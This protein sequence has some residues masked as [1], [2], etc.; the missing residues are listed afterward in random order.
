[1]SWSRRS[2]G[3]E[4][5]VITRTARPPS[6]LSPTPASAAPRAIVIASVSGSCGDPGSTS[7]AGISHRA[8]CAT[9]CT[10]S[11]ANGLAEITVNQSGRHCYCQGGQTRHDVNVGFGEAER[12]QVQPAA[13]ISTARDSE[14]SGH[15]RGG[16]GR[17]PADEPAAP[18]LGS[19]LTEPDRG[20]QEGG[21][22]D[23]PVVGPGNRRDQQAGD[24][25][26]AEAERLVA[27]ALS[28]CRGGESGN[29]DDDRR[30]QPDRQDV[31]SVQGPGDRAE[32]ALILRVLYRG[33]P[34]WPDEGLVP[35]DD[36]TGGHD[37]VADADRDREGRHRGSGGAEAPGEQQV[38]DEDR[39]G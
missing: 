25:A 16:E 27:L 13:A 19:A 4:S 24:R 36:G 35:E 8:P 23:D 18:Q 37:Q 2:L 32:Q 6:S 33:G 20:E 39:R 17:R 12:R 9:G 3:G 21:Y 26:H 34:A 31:R 1:M 28:S 15:R 11:S 7:D 30:R 38:E 22:R 29:G 5:G 14:P 10:D